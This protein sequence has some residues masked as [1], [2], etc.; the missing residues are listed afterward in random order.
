MTAVRSTD[1][2]SLVGKMMVWSCPPCPPYRSRG[3]AP[4]IS[5]ESGE[6]GVIS[7]LAGGRLVV[8]CAVAWRISPFSSRIAAFGGILELLSMTT[9]RYGR[10]RMR[11]PV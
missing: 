8:F 5:P 3:Q 10:L 9:R 4:D 11:F 1:L 6:T 2:L 7:R